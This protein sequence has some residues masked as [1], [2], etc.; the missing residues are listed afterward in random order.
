[1]FQKKQQDPDFRYF[2][3]LDTKT[4]SY[5]DPVQAVNHLDLIRQLEALMTDPERQKDLY[6]SN[7]EDFQL[8]EIGSYSRKTGLI[9]AQQ[10]KHVIN[11]IEIKTSA[12]HRIM[13]QLPQMPK[14][15]TRLT[16]VQ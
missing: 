4:N 5:R 2:T 6:V 1:M 9:E 13:Q 12:T 14:E 11:L 10:P 3:I 7:A 15:E 16:P 8:F